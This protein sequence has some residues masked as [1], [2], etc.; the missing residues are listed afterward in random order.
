MIQAAFLRV[1]RSAC[2][3]AAQVLHSLLRS[4]GL[5]GLGEY[6]SRDFHSLQALQR[7]SLWPLTLR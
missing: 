4:K 1:R 2:R 7:F 3:L 6:S 5:P